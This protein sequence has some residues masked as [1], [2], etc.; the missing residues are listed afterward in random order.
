MKLSCSFLILA[1]LLPTAA[2]AETIAII[3]TG[4]VANALGP[5]FANQGH[6]IVYGS[7][8]PQSEK[9]RAVVAKTAGGASVASPRDAVS[10]ASIVVMAIPGELVEEITLGL[11]D[12]SGKIIIDPTNPL[13]GDWDTE[14]S[15]SVETSNARIIQDAAPDAFVVKAFST[16]NWRQMVEPGGNISI[17]LAGDNACAKKTV[18]ALVEA[19]DLHPIDLGDV[20]AA[21]WIEG[22][23][24]LWLNNRIAGRSEFEYFLRPID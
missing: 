22:M 12:L 6:T 7:R 18:A 20:D 10:D 4:S 19:M 17:P 2:H 5:E 15:L 16:L 8:D 9:A 3:G 24:I 11:G 1:L 13:T 23:T 14:L 21:H